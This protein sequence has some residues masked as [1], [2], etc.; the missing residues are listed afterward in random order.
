MFLGYHAN[1]SSS[2][3]FYIVFWCSFVHICTIGPVDDDSFGW[4]PE[5]RKWTGNF[6]GAKS[7]VISFQS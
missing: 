6:K 1:K 7:E 5:E 4:I 3:L 2:Y